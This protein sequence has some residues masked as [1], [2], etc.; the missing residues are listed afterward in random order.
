MF[1]ELDKELEKWGYCYVWY[2]DD[3]SIYVRS[4]K[5]VWRVGNGIYYFLRDCLCLFINWEKSG[6]CRFLIFE[7]LG[8]VFVFSYKK[9]EKGKY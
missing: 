1:Y 5:V 9:G 6:I 7:L 3:F 8:Y 4:K 2:V